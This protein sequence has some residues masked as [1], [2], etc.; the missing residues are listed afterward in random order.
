MVSSKTKFNC[1]CPRVLHPYI[2]MHR[3]IFLTSLA[4]AKRANTQRT[5]FLLIIFHPTED[6]TCHMPIAFS[7]IVWILSD[8][9][10]AFGQKSATKGQQDEYRAAKNGEKR[11]TPSRNDDKDKQLRLDVSRT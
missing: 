7:T 6:H 5:E 1:S 4:H 3:I 9:L 2:L 8:H 11:Q 10:Y